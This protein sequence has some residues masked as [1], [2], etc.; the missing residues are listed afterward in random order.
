MCDSVLAVPPATADGAVWLGKNSDREPGEAQIVEHLPAQSN[1]KRAVLRCT[2]IEIPQSPH[3]TEVLICRPFWM[4]GAEMGIN[5]SGVAIGNHAVFT[6]V[7][8]EKTGLTGMDLVRLGLERAASARE[9]LDVIVHLIDKHG[10]GGGCG[11]RYRRFRYHNSFAIADPVEA[12]VLETAG[13]HWAAQRVRGIRTVSNCLS[14]GSEFDLASDRAYTYARR[15]GWC[16]SAADFEFARC[17]SDGAASR[18]GG[19]APRQAC[20]L[21]ALATKRGRLERGDFFTALRDHA[22]SAVRDGRLMKMPCAHASWQESR[23]QG[24]TTGSMICRL[25]REDQVCWL[26]GTSS[27]CISVYKP[28]RLNGSILDAGPRPGAGFDP[29]S[30]F[31]RHEYLHRLVI[32][33]Y[34]AARG[35]FEEDRSALESRLAERSDSGAR[36]SKFWNEHRTAL[37][38]WIARVQDASKGPTTESQ[39]LRYWRDQSALDQFPSRW[40]E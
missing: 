20:T 16:D 8:Y 22:G 7:P 36:S 9:A 15:Q 28:V 13:P 6:K 21:D 30:L 1:S 5:G 25:S 37:A 34:S 18:S 17:Y 24:Q 33:D 11:Y 2:Y 23:R 29:E 14:I 39:F 12:W 10:Q 31:W 19:G 32:R 3:T 4:W 26:T 38:E 40:P 27:P 35:L